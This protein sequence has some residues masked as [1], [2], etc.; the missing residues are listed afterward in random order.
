MIKLGGNVIKKDLVARSQSLLSLLQR[1]PLRIHLYLCLVS[2]VPLCRSAVA[3]LR[4]VAAA[5]VGVAREN[6]I[7]INVFPLPFCHQRQNGKNTIRSYLLRNGSYGTTDF[8]R[9]GNVIFTALTEFLRNLC[10][11][12]GKTERWKLGITYLLTY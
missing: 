5:A 4:S 6:G 7:S 11:G 10:N 2:S 3:V 1:E 8:L 12:N 9:I